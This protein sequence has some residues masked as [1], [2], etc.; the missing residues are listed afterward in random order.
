MVVVF[1]GCRYGHSVG[2][3][4]DDYLSHGHRKWTACGETTVENSRGLRSV[5][6]IC[7]YT[8]EDVV[9]IR[10]QVCRRISMGYVSRSAWVELRTYHREQR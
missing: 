7:P 8:F 5:L 2:P 3:I 9:K 10:I 6:L 4:M 1:N